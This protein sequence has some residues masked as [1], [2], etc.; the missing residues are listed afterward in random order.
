MQTWWV[1]TDTHLFHLHPNWLSIFAFEYLKPNS[2]KYM[3]SF[4]YYSDTNKKVRKRD[5]ETYSHK[6]WVWNTTG[7]QSINT[8]EFRWK[9]SMPEMG[10]DLIISRL[11]FHAI[12]TRQRA[13][14]LFSITYSLKFATFILQTFWIKYFKILHTFIKKILLKNVWNSLI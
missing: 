11:V 7:M 3:V 12:T 8:L 1:S 2:E 5:R 10:L 9:Y 4:C 6:F 14:D 13:F